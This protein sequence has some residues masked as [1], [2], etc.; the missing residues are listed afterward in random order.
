MGF[1][2]KLKKAIQRLKGKLIVAAIMVIII[3]CWAVAPFTVSVIRAKQEVD[4]YDDY[5]QIYNTITKFDW[6]IF[7]ETLGE[8]ITKPWNAVVICITDYFSAFFYVI[9]WFLYAYSLAVIVGIVRA[10]PKHQYEDIENGSS[11]WC[12]N[13][14]Q[15]A[16]L[17]RNKGI[18]L[19]EHNYLPV[20]KR[21]NV[22]VLV[23][24][25]F[26]CR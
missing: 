3:I 13:G 2:E 17:S 23:V 18:L 10:W 26:W 1:F 16:V 8:L 5:E 4:V 15:Y 9:R 6:Q 19:A 22:N 21:G 24:R 12:E 14:E 7:L 11:D 20:D 25:R